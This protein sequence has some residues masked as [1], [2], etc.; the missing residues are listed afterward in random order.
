MNSK[1]RLKLSW[2][3]TNHINKKFCKNRLIIDKILF[4]NSIRKS[5]GCGVVHGFYDSNSKMIGIKN[6]ISLIEQIETLCHELTHA[7]QHQI[8]KN[9]KLVHNKVG[10]KIF[11]KF[12]KS[13]EDI[14][15]ISLSR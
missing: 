13:T 9:N 1:E 5:K 2:K 4:F 3:I 7:Y 15:K 6:D 14:L 11:S 12:M 8:E 10:N